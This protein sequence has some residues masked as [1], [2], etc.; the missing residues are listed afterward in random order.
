MLDEEN[1]TE[2]IEQSFY[3]LVEDFDP[4]YI[5][6]Q[7][8]CKQEELKYALWKRKQQEDDF[9]LGADKF[10]RHI[11]AR[12]RIMK[13]RYSWTGFIDDYKR[14]SALNNL[15]AWYHSEVV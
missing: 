7:K 5:K 15:D 9:R 3:K 10:D 8:D 13:K 1:L 14:E 2:T 6:M 12:S 4:D 11:E